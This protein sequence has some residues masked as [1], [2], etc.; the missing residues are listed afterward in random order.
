[1][2]NLAVIGSKAVNGV[3]AVHSELVKHELFSDFYQLQPE[4]F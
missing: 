4:K 1:M 2:A 3:A